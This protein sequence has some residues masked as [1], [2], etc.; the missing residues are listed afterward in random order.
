M[1]FLSVLK[2]YRMCFIWRRSSRKL[3]YWDIYDADR[4]LTGR[5][6]RR[7]DWNMQPGDYHLTVLG[8]VTNPDGYFLITKRK[9]NKQWMPGAWEVSGGGVQAGE[10]SL[11][12]VKREVAEETGLDTSKA[13]ITLADTYRSDSPEEKNNYFVDIYHLELDFDR[14][15][16]QCQESE[17]DGFALVTYEDLQREGSEGNFL[18]Y[19]RLQRAFREISEKFM[20]QNTAM[21]ASD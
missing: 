16:V 7:N 20:R 21:R 2:N 3:E 10:T 14:G 5:R 9:R 17:T 8:I 19:N 4:N 13:R 15:D 1:Y 11:E 6:M 18:H 12:A